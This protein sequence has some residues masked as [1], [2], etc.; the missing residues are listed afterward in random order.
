MKNRES[1]HDKLN[2]LFDLET[3]MSVD[4]FR[5]SIDNAIDKSLE[6]WGAKLKQATEDLHNTET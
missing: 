6:Q 2:R 1:R 3:C 5:A 4:E